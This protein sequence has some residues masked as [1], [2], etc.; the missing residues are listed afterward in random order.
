MFSFSNRLPFHND[1]HEN[2]RFHRQ[3]Q[4]ACRDWIF[5]VQNDY[6]RLKFIGIR[7]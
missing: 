2:H 5:A 6:R 1:V 4:S 3:F 7:D